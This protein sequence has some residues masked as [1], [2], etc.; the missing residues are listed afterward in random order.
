MSITVFGMN[1]QTAPVA[2]REQ[3]AFAA[4]LYAVGDVYSERQ[5]AECL[6]QG[7]TLG[8]SL[9]RHFYTH[10]DEAAVRHPLRVACGLDSMVVGEL[11]ILG[12]VK[13]V[14]HA[15]LSQGTTGKQLNQLMQ[16]AFGIAK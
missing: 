7:R 13:D 15:A 1:H 3:V 4:E 12:Q 5:R 10:T 6:V 11:Q 9:A 16:Y 14:Y 8:G 2:D